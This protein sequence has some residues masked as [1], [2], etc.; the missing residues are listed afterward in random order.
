VGWETSRRRQRLPENWHDIRLPVLRDADWICEL[1]LEGVCRGTATDVD[2]IR[3]GDDHSRENLRAVCF[4]CHAKKSSMEGHA[5]KK[6]LSQLRKRRQE[7]HPGE[8]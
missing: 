6:E 3:R 4:R 7:R 1:Q 5:R 2:H 8:R